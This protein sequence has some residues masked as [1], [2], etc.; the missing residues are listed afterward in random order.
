[1]TASRATFHGRG[2]PAHDDRAEPDALRS[3]ANAAS[4][5]ARVVDAILVADVNTVPV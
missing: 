5:T 1:V 4:S 3:R 2:E